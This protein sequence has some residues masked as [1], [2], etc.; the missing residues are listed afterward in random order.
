MNEEAPTCRGFHK[1]REE[2]CY[3]F[4]FFAAFFAAFF[5]GAAFF[6][7]FFFAAFF[8]MVLKV[9]A[10]RIRW[11]RPKYESEPRCTNHHLLISWIDPSA[12]RIDRNIMLW[13]DDP[14]IKVW[15]SPHA[16]RGDDRVGPDRT[17]PGISI[18]S[19]PLPLSSLA[20]GGGHRATLHDPGMEP[21]DPTRSSLTPVIG[22]WPS[23]PKAR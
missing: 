16:R 15:P 23:H 8:A 19:P 22:T 5:F 21:M 10:K 12:L 14:F 2:R 4:F 13:T 7:A 18:A 20:M 9:C 6:A 3:Y 1:V 11:T 17:D